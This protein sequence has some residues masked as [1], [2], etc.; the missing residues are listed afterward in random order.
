MYGNEKRF[1]F[2][3]DLGVKEFAIVN[4]GIK[5]KNINKTK[6]VKKLEKKLKREQRCL[7]RKYENKK[8]GDATKSAKNIDKQILN[9]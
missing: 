5:K 3:V 6:K 8:K 7:S 9:V 4:N 2:G 1:L